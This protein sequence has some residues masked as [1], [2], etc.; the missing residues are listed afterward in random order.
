MS[1]TTLGEVYSWIDIIV[2]CLILIA[3]L[4][5]KNFEVYEE[6]HLD[7]NTLYASQYTIMVT[8]LPP[9]VTGS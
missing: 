1:R 8:N 9:T 7:K 4:W 2:V 6:T 3:Y 5:L